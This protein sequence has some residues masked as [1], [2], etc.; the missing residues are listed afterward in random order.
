ML[1]RFR[2]GLLFYYFGHVDQVSHAY[3]EKRVL[4]NV[5]LAARRGDRIAIVGLNGA[6]KTTTVE[7][8]EG[9][10]H[11]DG[12]E[13]AVLGQD[14][15]TAGRAWRSRL[16]IVLQTS[17]EAA[18]L[19]VEEMVRHFARYYPAPRDP[20][21][22][23]D[24]VGLQERR[25]ARL[26]ALSGGQR[27]R[28]DVALGIVGRPRLV[29]LDEPTTG[30]DVQ[31]RDALW[32]ALRSYRASGGT[33]LITSHYLAEIEALCSR[34]VVIDQGRV[35]A[36]GTVEEIRGQVSLSRVTVRTSASREV[37]DGL[38]G[39][40]STTRDV[41]NPERW[42]VHTRSSD[43]LVRALVE[44]TAFEDLEVHRASLEEAFVALTS[45]TDRR[46]ERSRR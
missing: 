5:R 44:S 31:A 19:T 41:E 40:V 20:D 36:D 29:V 4:D 9:Y 11:R 1:D 35:I 27:R 33:L 43:A 18:E 22:V 13:V 15:A 26:R 6:G 23:I 39:V 17:A 8:L 32:A 16:G 7:I 38:P 42:T 12:G 14:P 25:T 34:V 2:D 10:R 37:L 24:A 21:Q 28:L 45:T 30:L 3:G 46:S